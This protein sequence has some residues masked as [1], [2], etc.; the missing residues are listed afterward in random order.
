MQL[1]GHLNDQ[2]P[3]ALNQDIIAGVTQVYTDSEAVYVYTSS[4]PYYDINPN[5]TYLQNNNIEINDAK[6]FKKIPK[7][8][9]KSVD[10]LQE[11]TPANNVVGILRDGTYI[12]QLEE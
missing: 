10:T 8:F 5:G 12:P 1:L 3:L 9:E 7:V 6:L 4:I 2:T 11:P